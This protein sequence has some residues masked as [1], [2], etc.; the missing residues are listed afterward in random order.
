MKH[1]RF[2]DDWDRTNNS[3]SSGR[4]TELALHLIDKIGPHR[5]VLWFR[6][7]DKN[8]F[9]TDVT[10]SALALRSELLRPESSESPDVN[11]YYHTAE[12]SIPL[13][14]HFENYMKSTSMDPSRILVILDDLNGLDL[15]GRDSI[16]QMLRKGTLDI[17][18]TG[19]DGSM[20]DR[21]MLWEAKNFNVPALEDEFAAKLL[22]DCVE[23]TGLLRRRGSETSQIDCTKQRAS[24]VIAE[25]LGA[26]PAAIIN[27]SHYLKDRF[28]GEISEDHSESLISHFDEGHVLYYRR[29]EGKYRHTVFQSFE[30]SLD[31]L[32]R[33]TAGKP[34]DNLYAICNLLLQV[35]SAM[36]IHAIPDKNLERF[37]WLLNDG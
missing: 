35:L 23:D 3:R 19:R 36:Q 4:K 30:V 6:A 21:G 26:L 29:P 12:G 11:H 25:W 28:Y 33:N 18:Y 17:M 37:V 1:H 9:E 14:T 5:Y 13:S 32:G 15:A 34:P 22:Q 20:A 27:G 8:M 2:R 7:N 31:R 10:T 16:S 24:P